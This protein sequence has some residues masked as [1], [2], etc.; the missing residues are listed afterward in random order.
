MGL[1]RESKEVEAEGEEMHGRGDLI[2]LAIWLF[3]RFSSFFQNFL[4]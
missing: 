4:A 2:S 1:G 3:T